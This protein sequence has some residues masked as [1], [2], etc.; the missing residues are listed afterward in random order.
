MIEGLVG[1]IVTVAVKLLEPVWLGD[2]D[3]EAVA[4]GDSVPLD[5]AEAD[6][7]P[8]G[9][10]EPDSEDDKLSVWETEKEGVTLL[11]RDR[12]SE[13]LK[14]PDSVAEMQE[15]V[16]MEPLVVTLADWLE[17]IEGDGE[18]LSDAQGEAVAQPL[19]VR[20]GVEDAQ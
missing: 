13:P 8:L 16:E 3:A 10:A 19:Y 18:A 9:D 1:S 20:E 14:E 15:V 6:R 5:E 4:L 2:L 17:E 11:E 12:R 7:L